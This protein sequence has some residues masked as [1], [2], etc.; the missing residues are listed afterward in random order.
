MILVKAG[1]F[2]RE[3]EYKEVEDK[4]FMGLFSK[5]VTKTA[6]QKVTLTDDFEIGFKTVQINY[7][8]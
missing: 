8:K 2:N 5:K 3:Y 4:G 1:F 7:F 6:T